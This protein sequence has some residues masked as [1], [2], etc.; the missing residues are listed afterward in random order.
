MHEAWVSLALKAQRGEQENTTGGPR[1]GILHTGGHYGEL[2]GSSTAELP[3]SFQS[4]TSS[5]EVRA[6]VR[7]S[8]HK[9]SWVSSRCRLQSFGGRFHQCQSVQCY[10]KGRESEIYARSTIDRVARPSRETSLPLGER[11]LSLK[12]ALRD[13][14][15]AS[16]DSCNLQSLSW[17]RECCTAERG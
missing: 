8:K 6:K 1:R 12:S 13:R 15:R 10:G 2:G 9:V 3:L 16:R 11:S 7:S 14:A 5:S 17:H 4:V